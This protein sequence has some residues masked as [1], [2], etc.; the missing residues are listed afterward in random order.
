M[1]SL[2]GKTDGRTTIANADDLA[3]YLLQEAHVA[4]VAGTDFG[5]DQ[6]LRLSF[7]A[8]EAQLREAVKRIA[9]A[10]AKLH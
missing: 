3:I 1:S 5:S 4:C 7:A 8:S 2:F 6:C 10:V 9:A